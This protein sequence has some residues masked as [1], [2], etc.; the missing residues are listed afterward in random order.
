[1]GGFELMGLADGWQP[2]M[3]GAQGDTWNLAAVTGEWEPLLRRE[4]FQDYA[5]A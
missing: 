1:M 5:V 4:W 3:N 2:A